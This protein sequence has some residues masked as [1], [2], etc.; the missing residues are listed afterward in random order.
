MSEAKYRLVFDNALDGI[1]LTGPCGSIAQANPAACTLFRM[2]EDELVRQDWSGLVDASEP[3]FAGLLEE[4][5][6]T[7]NARGEMAMKRGDGTSFDAEVASATYLDASGASL[8]SFF[9]RDITQRKRAREAIL[10]ARTR[11]E[12][13]VRQRTA[14]LET[15]NRDLESFALSVAH[16]LRG[17]LMAI[18]NFGTVLQEREASRFSEKGLHY[19]CRIREATHSMRDMTDALLKLAR[20]SHEGLNK[21][22]LDLAPIAARLLAELREQSPARNVEVRVAPRITAWADRALITRVLENLISNAWKFSAS[23][24]FATIEVGVAPQSGADR[25]YFVKDNGVGFRL[26]EARCLFRIF[27]RLHSAA[28]YEGTGAGL[29]TVHKVVSRHGGKVWAQAA[30]GQGATFFFTLGESRD[31]SAGAARDTADSPVHRALP[32]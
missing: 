8:T 12:E 6:R 14:E 30:P 24:P 7:G 21:E 9:V 29:A 31:E 26:E 2:S 16:D 22:D 4:R 11:L 17:P 25:A 20:L 23:Q 28:D 15:A 3:G 27:S 19:L 1:L 10:A 5:A 32:A 13:R 18:G